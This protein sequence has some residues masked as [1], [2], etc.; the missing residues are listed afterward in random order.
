MKTHGSAIW[1]GGIKDGKGAISTRSGALKDY[2]YGFSS[3]FGIF[4]RLNLEGVVRE[5][6]QLTSEELDFRREAR[7]AALFHAVLAQDEVDHYAPRVYFALCGRRVITMERVEGVRVTDL[8]VAVQRG[9]QTQLRL[10]AGRGIRRPSLG[11]GG[12]CSGLMRVKP[13]AGSTSRCRHVGT[14]RP[15]LVIAPAPG[16]PAAPRRR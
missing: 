7:N 10:W 6:S 15:W 16:V 2:P 4:R 12:G 1:Q 14:L 13:T 3:R 9:D 11:S 8:L 5:L